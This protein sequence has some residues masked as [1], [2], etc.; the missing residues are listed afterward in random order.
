[1]RQSTSSSTYS[2]AGMVRPNPRGMNN[3]FASLRNVFNSRGVN[4]FGG[5]SI[6]GMYNNLPRGRPT[7]PGSNL[8]LGNLFIKYLILYLGVRLP[9]PYPRQIPPTIL[10]RRASQQGPPRISPMTQQQQTGYGPLPFSEMPQLTSP[11]SGYSG[12]ENR[13]MTSSSL[14]NINPESNMD[15]IS[16]SSSS[17]SSGDEASP[18]NS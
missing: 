1:M 14:M 2:G 10:Q 3:P 7:G 11:T 17:S 12:F 8:N 9:T 18:D 15:Q 13:E 6:P 4:I 5:N 16:S